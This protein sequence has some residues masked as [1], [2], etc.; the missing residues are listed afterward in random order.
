MS[1]ILT[2]LA[3]GIAAVAGVRG[4][5]SPCGLSMVSALNPMA[6]RGRGH[7]YWLTAAWY[8]VGAVAGGGLLGAGCAVL[9][10]G[11]SALGLGWHVRAL[12][13]AAAALVCW[14]SD[15]TLVRWS[16]PIH[17]RQVNE[18]WIGRYRRWIYAAGFGVQIGTG[19]A[20][21]VMSATVYLTAGLAAST[22][23]PRLALAVGIAFGAVRGLGVCCGALARTPDRLRAVL[24]RLDATAA[25]SLRACV[26]AEI[27]A[28]AVALGTV[29][30]RAALPAAVGLA[31]LLGA[32]GLRTSPAAR[33]RFRPGWKSDTVV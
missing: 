20:T 2:G 9:A 27:A 31:V 15:G 13:A 24:V 10:A 16:L 5:W 4:L 17:P 18:R 11:V 23:S 32:A 21:Y 3:F 26:A 1:A 14:L 22:G 7:R 8:L 12:L 6:E 28:A 30:G 29:G 33:G 25:A 19:F